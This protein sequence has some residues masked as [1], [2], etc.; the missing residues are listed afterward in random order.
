MGRDTRKSEIIDAVL[1]FIIAGGITATA[2]FAPNALLILDKPLAK[3]YK[4][5]DAIAKE[6]EYKQL[7]GYMKKRGLIKYGYRNFNG[8]KLTEAGIK[9]AEK[10]DLDHLTIPKPS[11]WDKKWRLVFFDIPEKYKKGRDYFSAKLK[12]IGFLQL[13][14]SVW[15]HPYPCRDEIAA[16][17]EQYDLRRFVTFVETETIDSHDELTRTFASYF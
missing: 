16:I 5:K 11:K 13:Q 12:E 7:L 9:R 17:A 2:I 3:Y 1:Q 14:K 10:A 8:I 15:I 6:K 4:H